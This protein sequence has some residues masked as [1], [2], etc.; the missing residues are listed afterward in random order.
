MGE[1]AAILFASEIEVEYTMYVQYSEF[2][3]DVN[4]DL[5][6]DSTTLQMLVAGLPL[7]GLGIKFR[8]GKWKCETRTFCNTIY[9]PDVQIVFVDKKWEQ[10]YQLILSF[11]GQLHYHTAQPTKMNTSYSS[12]LELYTREY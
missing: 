1:K 5:S 3:E 10:P 11:N 4:F 12:N 8:K 9:G 7:P 6:L 2:K